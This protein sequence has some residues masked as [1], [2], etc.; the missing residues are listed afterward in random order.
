[1][2]QLLL[3]LEI[4]IV[5]ELKTHQLQWLCYRYLPYVSAP[6]IASFED[7][8]KY[9]WCLGETIHPLQPQSSIS[10]IVLHMTVILYYCKYASFIKLINLC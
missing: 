9:S 6:A 10:V 3:F 7:V 5:P 8:G 4:V 2:L 1:M